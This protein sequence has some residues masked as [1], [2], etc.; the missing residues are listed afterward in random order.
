MS[1]R[2][3][4]AAPVKKTIRVEAPRARAFDVFTAGFGTWW[5]KTHHIG[6]AE[7]KEAVIELRAGGRWYE[8]GVDGSECT[9]GKVLA[10]EP[11]DRLV[12][13]WHLNGKFELD[14]GVDSQVE[15]R[16]IADGANATRVEL[17]HRIEAADAETIRTAVDSP[18]GWSV[19]LDAF[20]KEAVA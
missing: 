11:P 12:L 6:K 4:S 10:W 2:T 18:N 5:P 9:W 14:E 1:T 20:A 16:F 8:K 19:L 13:S 15:I 17:E 3:I 7:M